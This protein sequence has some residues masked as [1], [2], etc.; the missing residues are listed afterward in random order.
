MFAAGLQ[1]DPVHGKH[2][3]LRYTINVV[4]PRGAPNHAACSTGVQV[5][6]TSNLSDAAE[7]PLMLVSLPLQLAQR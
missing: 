1:Q 6:H 3:K 2:P 7:M 5:L 4:K